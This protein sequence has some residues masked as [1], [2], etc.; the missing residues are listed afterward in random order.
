MTRFRA[1]T[2][3][4]LTAFIWG[5]AFLAQKNASANMGPFLFLGL[6]FFLSWLLILPFAI[7][8]QFK[9]TRALD[10]KDLLC[11]IAIGICLLTATSLQQYAIATASVTHAGFLTA[12]YFSFVPLVNWGL[13]KQAPRPLIVFACSISLL[14]A[15]LLCATPPAGVWSSGDFIILISDVIWAFHI[16]LVSEFLSQN[17]RPFML[18][19]TQYGMTALLAFSTSFLFETI[20]L[21]SILR[22]GPSILY[23]GLLSGGLAYTLQIIAQRSTPPSEAALIMS[24]ESVFAALAGAYF[25]HD[26]LT[27]VGF[28]G[29]AL[30][31]LGAVLVEFLPH[32]RKR[33]LGRR[34]RQ[35]QVCNKV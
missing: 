19:V 20:D 9:A 5:T 10:K 6:R 14:G 18:A 33:F 17:N 2:L 35:P 31:L 21:S 1:D 27:S 25:Y 15:W 30:I 16:L 28:L 3:L 11:A 4:L 32:L 24:L 26:R 34:S 29:C 23:A 7:R 13:K 8:E 12:A 22:T